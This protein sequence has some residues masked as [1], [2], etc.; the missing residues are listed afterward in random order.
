ME[1]SPE[2]GNFVRE[3]QLSKLSIDFIKIWYLLS[4]DGFIKSWNRTVKK[5]RLSL[6]IVLN[7]KIRYCKM[8]ILQEQTKIINLFLEKMSLYLFLK[9][10][11]EK[12]ELVLPRTTGT[13]KWDSSLVSG[14][15]LLWPFFLPL[16]V[17]FTIQTILETIQIAKRS[18][19]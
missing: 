11:I 19:V 7:L 12:Y 8:K 18:K 16:H 17:I 6:W 14:C 15:Q 13:L 2:D 4:L 3:T 9:L 5:F 10:K 1:S